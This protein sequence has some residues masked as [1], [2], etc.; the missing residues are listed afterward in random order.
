MQ[1]VIFDLDG[2]LIDS[3]DGIFWQYQK[4][5]EEFDGAPASSEE[6]AAAMHGTPETIIRTLV[7]NTDV[8]FETIVAR[9]AV[10]WQ[11]SASLHH[12]YPGVE[13]LLII[14]KRLGKNVGVVTASDQRA[15]DFLKQQGVH[16]H[17]DVIV[18]G[19]DNVQPKPHP[20]GVQAVL[21][22]LGVAPHE[23]VMIGDTPA[24]ILAGKRAGTKTVGMTHGFTSLQTL[25]SVEPD[26][27]VHDIPSLLDVIE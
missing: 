14:L 22:K 18:T 1:A 10:L 21:Q 24:D 2:T 26:F 15:A 12:L 27:I 6:I 9:H 25:Q 20:E 17:F 13:D 11:Q 16:E 5:T 8:P 7:K 3:R 19:L 23:A 4:L